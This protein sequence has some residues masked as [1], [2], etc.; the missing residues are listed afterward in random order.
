MAAG[1]RL[2]ERRAGIRRSRLVVVLSVAPF[3][4][5][6]AGVALGD[7]AL[8]FQTATWPAREDVDRDLLLVHPAGSCGRPRPPAATA[9]R[10][11]GVSRA[12][13]RGGSTSG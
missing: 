7:V 10:Q 1:Y 12:A 5:F 6:A 11:A 13:S 9:P 2:A 3:V 8:R 4:A